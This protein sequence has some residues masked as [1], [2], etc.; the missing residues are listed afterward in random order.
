MISLGLSRLGIEEAG[1]ITLRF[2]HS[3]D[4]TSLSKY[5][6]VCVTSVYDV[7]HPCQ[8]VSDPRTQRNS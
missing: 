7:L 3:K 5:C 6:G 1:L 8:I 2:L 4:L